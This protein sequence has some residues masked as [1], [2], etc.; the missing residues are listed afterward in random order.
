MKTLVTVGRGGTGKSSFTALMA[1]N[2]IEAGQ[3]PL[4]LV[5]ADPDQNLGEMIGID[6]KEVGKSTI[7]DLIVSTFIEKG[8]TTVGVPPRER[9]ESRIWENGLYESKS[10][11]F[12]SVGTKWVEGCYCMPNSALKAALESLTKNYKYVL[13]DS[14][15]GLENL[16]RRI[17]SDV[18]DIFDILDHS[19]K[20]QDHVRRAVKIAKEVDMKFENFYL[21]GGYRFPSELGKQAEA[22]LKYKYLGKIE[23]DDQLDEFVLNGKSLLD[24]PKDNKAYLSVQNILKTLGYL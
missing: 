22:D 10:F 11:D 24:L 5:D 14:P 21:V 1:K 7:A 4:L 13:V 16:N 20:S 3:A 2:F 23:A 6:L 12:L 15:A 9:I 17:T 8:G 19:K 18:N